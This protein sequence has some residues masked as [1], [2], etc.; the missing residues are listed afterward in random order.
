MER[1]IGRRFPSTS[2]FTTVVPRPRGDDTLEKVTF[3]LSD[4]TSINAT[5]ASSSPPLAS[6]SSSSSSP[7]IRPKIL[8]IHGL[9]SNRKT[10]D[11]LMFHLIKIFDVCSFDLRNHGDNFMKEEKQEEEE[12]EEEEQSKTVYKALNI[13]TFADD[14]MELTNLLTTKYGHENNWN[15]PILIGHSYGGNI[16]LEVGKKYPKLPCSIVLL[17]GGYI[18]LQN[19]FDGNWENCKEKCK[20]P[21]DQN[22]PFHEF[23]PLFRSYYPLCSHLAL[24]GLMESFYLDTET[25]CYR[26]KVSPEFYMDMIEDLWKYRPCERY[27]EKEEKDHSVIN[28]NVL[29]LPSGKEAFFSKDKEE[30]ITKLNMTI[31][32]DSTKTSINKEEKVKIWWFEENSH[33][34][35]V[36][37]AFGC[38]KAIFENMNFLGIP[39]SNKEN[40]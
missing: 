11:E 24:N 33:D 10:F 35:H 28:C 32:G 1:S 13:E 39:A 23:I 5:L 20:Q 21:P 12:E 17:D 14:V 6:T 4:E 2:V 22:I 30:D 31:N 38:A 34:I 29:I 3:I 9:G 19:C 37:N 36:E 18:D 26:M 15:H 27:G 16:A 40:N 8:L 25:N 7:S